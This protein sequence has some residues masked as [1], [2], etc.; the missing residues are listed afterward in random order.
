MVRGASAVKTV[1]YYD[2]F[3]GISGDMNLGALIDI[4]VPEEYLRS[5]LSKLNLSGYRLETKKD[6]R[7][8]IYGTLVDV[9]LD[10]HHHDDAHGHEHHHE[11]RN[12]HDITHIINSSL[13]GEKVKLISLKIFQNIAEVEAKIHGTTTDK[14]HFH[15]VGA[16]DSIVDI[17]GAAICIDYLKPD[18]IHCSSVE[19]GGGFVKCAHGTFPVP[20]PATAEILQGVPVKS[21]AVQFETTTP[22]GAAILASCVNTF[23]DNKK[24]IIRKV[25]YGVGHR[26]TDIPNVLRVYLGELDESASDSDHCL[27]ECNLDDMTPEM[28]G[29]LIEKLLTKGA[30]DAYFTPIVMKKSRPAVMLSVLCHI[31]NEESLRTIIFAESSTFGMRRTDVKKF[32]LDRTVETVKTSLGNVRVKTAFIEGK[33][34]KMKPEFDDCRLIAE[35]KGMTLADVYAVIRREIL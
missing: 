33:K 2:C 29:Y 19:L 15:E 1:L 6:H 7:R 25:A 23:T 10:E 5:E 30:R 8:G 18:R 17:V 27:L 9:V 34:I 22:T 31:D 35:Q 14:I 21:G 24:F 3:S 26:D 28:C 12:L 16:V 32:E 13:L 20:A 11:H 4:G